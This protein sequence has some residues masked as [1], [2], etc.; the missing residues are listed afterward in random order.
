MIITLPVNG[1][2]VTAHY[3]DEEVETVHKPL[4]TYLAQLHQHTSRF[5]TI[6]FLSA[7]PGTGKSTLGAFWMWLAARMPELPPIQ[8]LPMDGFHH[9]NGWLEQHHLRAK[10]GAPETFDVDKLALNLQRIRHQAGDWPQYSRQSH[11]PIESAIDVTAPLVIVEG[12]WL[13]LNEP[14]WASLRQ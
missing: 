10:K 2:D 8:M 3:S 6:I 11:E 9:Y 4:L 12:N 1:F 5:R 7:P 13:L 14:R